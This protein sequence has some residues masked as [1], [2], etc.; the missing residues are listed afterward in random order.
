M[1]NYPQNS[2]TKR[3][4]AGLLAVWMSGVVFLFCCGASSARAAGAESCPLAKK[5]RC[6]K[7]S[8]DEDA[9]RFEAAQDGCPAF[10]CCGFLPEVFDKIKKAEQSRQIA[11]DCCKDG[12]YSMGG[13]C[14][15]DKDSCPM[16]KSQ[17]TSSAQSMDMS[18]VTVSV[19]SDDCCKPGADCC[20]GGACS[21][22]K[23]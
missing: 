9:V 20:K 4:F 6:D 15:K 12:K 11:A 16:K 13:D 2:T 17:E 19:S 21:H 22:K 7:S 3:I 5:S 18:K 1:K 10:N 23:S 8:T 14:C